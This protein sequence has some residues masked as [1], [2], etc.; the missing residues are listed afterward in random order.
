MALPLRQT[1]ISGDVSLQEM[2]NAQMDSV[3]YRILQEFLESDVD[4]GNI[5]V[6]STPAGASSI[7]S[8][9]D[10]RRADMVGTHPAGT[11]VYSDTTNFYQ[12]TSAETEN[13]ERPVEFDVPLDSIQEMD[14]S[15]LNSSIISR[16]LTMLT[17]TVNSHGLGQYR[18]QPSNP[19]NGTWSTQATIT[20][21]IANTAGTDYDE[22]TTTLWKK[23][24][25]NSTFSTHF[26][27]LKVRSDGH[28]QEMSDDEVKALVTRFRNRIIETGIGTYVVQEN[29]PSNGT[30]I[31]SGSAFDD[32]RRTREDQ[33]YSGDYTGSYSGT[34]SGSRTYSGSYTGNYSNT[35]TGNFAGTAY[36]GGYLGS[37]PIY[38]GGRLYYVN[39]YFTGFYSANYTNTF[40]GYF[41]GS[42][43]GSRTYSGNYTGSYSGTY[44]GDYTGATITTTSETPSQVSLWMRI[45]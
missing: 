3:A 36:A 23:T 33:S 21:R 14:N 30:W 38:Y 34:Y 6:G 44:T 17:S 8:F 41:A 20:N 4:A 27:P 18:L 45:S 15:D 26:R 42:Y 2:S 10:T 40:T 37:G 19:G 35:F 22:N 16:A 5:H 31:R 43:S 39:Q 12:Y 29:A 24:A 9:T 28:L 7:G 25:Q 1:T 11:T 32:T 13:F